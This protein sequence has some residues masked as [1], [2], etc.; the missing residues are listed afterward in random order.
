MILQLTKP[1]TRSANTNEEDVRALKRA[2][3][4]LD[5]YTPSG[6][7]GMNGIPDNGL[8]IALLLFQEEYALPA[9]GEIRPGDAT[10]EAINKALKNL[11]G[12]AYIWRTLGDDK[13]RS[14]HAVLNGAVK[15]WSDSP[16]PGEEFGC[17]CW[18]EPVY[19]A[20][21]KTFDPARDAVKPS[22]G[23]VEILLGGLVLKGGLNIGRTILNA[24][25]KSLKRSIKLNEAQTKNLARFIKKIPANSKNTVKI[26][27]QTNGNI[28]FRAV[29][30]GKAPRSRAIYEKTVNS[31]GETIRYTK[32]TIDKN[33]KI[34]HTK[35]K[36]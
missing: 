3:N 7:I 9:T 36:F 15:L 1:V 2:L 5:Y 19:G 28:K 8:F 23:P 24:L 17:R 35:D 33:G 26:T 6:T 29:S 31:K 22:I 25:I 30:Q 21:N 34:I 11:E 4:A 18:A 10:H 16:E 14:S 13:V 32:T 20:P 12:G 27:K